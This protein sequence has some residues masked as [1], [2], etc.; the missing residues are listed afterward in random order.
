MAATKSDFTNI[1]KSYLDVRI[2]A[3]MN[4]EILDSLMPFFVYTLQWGS[5]KLIKESV[6]L[7][8]NS[9][10]HYHPRN[11]LNILT[12]SVIAKLFERG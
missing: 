7:A 8:D 9:S 3:W 4:F 12:D 11:F 1:F 5:K 10:L 6:L 2:L